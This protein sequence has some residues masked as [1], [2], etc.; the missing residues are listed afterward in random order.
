MTRMPQ[1]TPERSTPP[2]L[3][4]P[5]LTP[6]TSVTRSTSTIAGALL[7]AVGI[8]GVPLSLVAALVTAN[9]CG[10]FADHCAQY[11]QTSDVASAFFGLVYL[12]VGA[13]VMGFVLIIAGRMSKSTRS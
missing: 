10:A 11:G 4:T 13:A 6:N 2:A 8:V 9:P 1:P 3:P 12:A 5:P 7:L